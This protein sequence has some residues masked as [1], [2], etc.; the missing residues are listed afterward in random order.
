MPEAQTPP[1]DPEAAAKEAA[2]AEEAAKDPKNWSEAKRQGASYI[3][4]VDE[5]V[6][7]GYK[8][9]DYDAFVANRKKR[10]E[11]L[12]LTP[13]SNRLLH[14]EGAHYVVEAA[15]Q[16]VRKSLNSHQRNSSM[17]SEAPRVGGKTLR[18]GVKLA[19]NETQ[20]KVMDLQLRR[21]H[22][23][24]AIEI[25]KVDEDGKQTNVRDVPDMSDA[26]AVL[27]G[28]ETPPS[29]T[30]LPPGVTSTSAPLADPDKTQQVQTIPPPEALKGGPD[31]TVF[32]VNPTAGA[33]DTEL[34]AATD[35]VGEDDDGGKVEGTTTKKSKRSHKK[36][37]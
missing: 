7:A 35:V 13:H 16:T 25:Y 15:L 34:D 20:M 17:F 37:G 2:A 33:T 29:G 9:E 26:E 27:D 4:G 23:A 10:I 12:G 30:E 8:A 11:E 14:P 24:H 1:V 31:P 28:P 19:L 3:P 6:K 21:L 22:K 5:Y 36:G 18:R 32:P